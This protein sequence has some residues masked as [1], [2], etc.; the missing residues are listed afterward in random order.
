MRS[1][2]LAPSE[3]RTSPSS[4]PFLFRTNTTSWRYVELGTLYTARILVRADLDRQLVKSAT[5]TLVIPELELTIPASRG[6]LTTVEGI[7]RDTVRDLEMDQPLRRIQDEATWEK[8][9]VLVGKMNDILGDEEE[10]KGDEE[11]AVG[12]VVQKS[13]AK[14]DKPMK[15]FTV[16]LDD[17]AGN[18]WI[19]FIGSMEDPKW[20]M[21]QYERTPE[22]NAAIGL[23]GGDAPAPAAEAKHVGSEREAFEA[24]KKVEAGPGE[25]DVV[26]NE[27]IYVFPGTCSS[28]SAP[29]DTMMKRVIIPY[30]KVRPHPLNPLTH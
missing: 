30:F 9:G 29:L 3:V 14:V 5:C 6:Q 24:G 19:E 26:P 22:Q 11:A 27:E 20:T 15:P 10:E 16:Q 7:V 8:I 4:P 13:A 1:N 17:P 25:D 12:A 21:R 2:P 23:G 28:C 18:S